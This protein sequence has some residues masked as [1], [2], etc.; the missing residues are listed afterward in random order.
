VDVNGVHDQEGELHRVPWKDIF[1]LENAPD[2]KC[3]RLRDPGKFIAGGVHGNPETWK[4]VLKDRPSAGMIK[5]KIDITHFCQ[6]FKGA[7]KVSSYDSDF[8]PPKF[9]RFVSEEI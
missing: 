9:M 8:P 2:L 3:L 6:Y 4:V 1:L 5:N 7:F